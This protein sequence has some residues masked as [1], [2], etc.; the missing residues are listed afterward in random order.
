MYEAKNME[1][2]KSTGRLRVAI[3]GPEKNGKSILTSTAR[4]V[5][6]VLDYDQRADALAGKKDVFAITLKDAGFPLLPT[7]AEE[8]LDILTG[9]EKSLDLSQLL[10]SRGNR[11]FPEVPEGTMVENIVHDSMSSLAKCVMQYELY[12]SKDLRRDINFGKLTVYIP[13]SYDSWNAEVGAVTN[14]VMRSM[15]LPINVFCIFH[16]AA[17]EAVDSTDEK[18]KYTGRVSIY[19]VRYRSLLK[20][21]NEV[22]RVKLTP[23]PISNG[24]RYLPRVYPLPDFS[25]DAA[26]TMNLDPVEEPDIA[27]MIA[28]NESRL[29]SP[30]QAEGKQLPAKVAGITK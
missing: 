28:K 6:L 1:H 24:V 19:P 27:K 16:E 21:F 14:I 13:K 5:K 3:I 9:L 10:D 29:S 7:V 4:G 18:P 26:T 23:V 20:Y 12:N 25:M 2:A 8:T 17:E 11:F 22:W 30:A 15:A